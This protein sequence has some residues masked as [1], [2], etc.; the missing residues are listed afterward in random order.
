MTDKAAAVSTMT[1]K[2]TA[3]QVVVRIRPPGPQ[4]A[5][6]Q[7]E[8]LSLDAGPPPQLSV[9]GVS[10]S[11]PFD[12]V[13]EA[14]VP[15]SSLFDFISP[16]VTSFMEGFNSTVLA[17]G[18]TG[19]GKT[20]TMLGP[21]GGLLRPSEEQSGVIP[22]VAAALFAGVAART[23]GAPGYSARVHVQYLELYNE[24]LRDLLAGG[25]AP[26]KEGGGGLP[27]REAE[28]GGLC[29]VGAKERECRC[30]ADVLQ[31]LEEGGH[32]R[33]TAAT[34][35]NE[36]SSRS[37]AVLT[38][39]L[40]QRL[41]CGGGVGGASERRASKFHLLDLA[42]SE[43]VKRTGAV[44]QRF[45]EGVAINTSLL[46][47]G[48]VICALSD[49]AA[50]GGGGGSGARGAHIPYRDSKLTR[51][52]QDSL[53]GNSKT[54]M[55]ACVS[56]AEAN[57][58][59][60]LNTLRYAARARAIRNAPKIN[61]GAGGAADAALAALRAE[62]AR[63]QEALRAEQGGGCGAARAAPPAL[64]LELL[65]ARDEEE[66]MERVAELR[67]AAARAAPVPETDEGGGRAP[68]PPPPHLDATL[69]LGLRRCGGDAGDAPPPP[70]PPLAPPPPLSLPSES[71]ILEA[72]GALGYGGGAEGGDGGDAGEGGGAAAARRLERLESHLSDMSQGLAA[73]EELA[74]ALAAKQ[75][76]LT[77]VTARYQAQFAAERAAKRALEAEVEALH[78]Q[79][80]RNACAAGGGRPE[81][82]AR[83]RALLADAQ[84]RLRAN[85]VALRDLHAVRASTHPPTCA[86]A[87]L[88]ARLFFTLPPPPL[89]P[90][91]P[92]FFEP[93]LFS[94]G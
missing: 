41:P 31:A 47:L 43:R 22:R 26:A 92:F 30:A 83:L 90:P 61:R 38:L 68:P 64:L 55:V 74:C 54:C 70:P 17:Y 60:S 48:N 94:T 66:A 86:R 76:E 4:D 9:Q 45:R 11:F 5:S 13:F 49:D 82:D 12:A 15:Q 16:L 78:A 6:E 1:D 29:V 36:H 73:K 50:R 42:G 57:L 10:S 85:E 32:S 91:T 25:G 19:S 40:E 69:L 67:A 87:L 8:W 37:H 20:H 59:E 88:H 44:G 52:L 62:V 77:A 81:E 23:A 56:S 35:M 79:V 89:R 71:E 84:A 14:G 65:G 3:V 39:S 80:E 53:G 58:E 46:A 51:L 33:V 93:P 24:E 7:P 34:L 21:P 63:L 72:L 28:G 75:A 2:A 18:Q 27:I